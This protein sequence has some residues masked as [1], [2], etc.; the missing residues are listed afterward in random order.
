MR[1]LSTQ[2]IGS[3]RKPSYLTSKFKTM[4]SRDFLTLAERA[5]KETIELFDRSGLDNI[6]VGGEMFRW[7]MYDH[8]ASRISGIKNYGPVRSFDNRYYIKGSVISDVSR[9]KSFHGEELEFLKMSGKKN[10][11]VPITGP[12]TLMDWSFNEHYGKREE[13]AMAFGELVNEEIRELKSLWGDQD[14]Q[15]QIDE[16]ATT[17]H[18]DE[19]GIVRDSIN[20]SVRGVSGI[21]THLHV[22]YS[23]DYSLLFKIIPDLDVSVYNLEFANRDNLS[24]EERPGYLDVKKF[25]DTANS[26]TRKIELGLGVTDVHIDNIETTALIEKRI[27]YA[28]KFLDPARI[29]INP[30]CGLR[31]RSREIGF[32]KLENMD[33]AR[34]SVAETL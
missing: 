7:E 23:S 10:V 29:R 31:T 18:P 3:F 13:L 22:C 24:G 28:M 9:I 32:E 6:G 14:L 20:E 8:P 5:T 1:E 15:I 19:M 26:M 34:H 27:R 4:E 2:E 30:D 21:E 25:A 33:E 12:Y 16:P 17:T 11:K